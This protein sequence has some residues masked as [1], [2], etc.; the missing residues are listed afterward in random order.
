[1]AIVFLAFAVADA[2]GDAQSVQ[3]PSVSRVGGALILCLVMLVCSAAA[4]DLVMRGRGS[5]AGMLR[6][7]VGGQLAKYVPG[8]IAQVVGQAGL[9]V[10][11]G[12]TKSQAVAGVAVHSLVGVVAPSLL[13][14]SLWSLVA[15]PFPTWLRVTSALASTIASLALVAHPTLR[16]LARVAQVRLRRAPDWQVPCW[17]AL[18]QVYALGL[19]ALA[20]L[21]VAFATLAG[22]TSD[23]SDVIAA[24]GGYGVAFFVGFLAVPIP[25]GIGVREGALLAVAAPNDDILTALAAAACLR[26]LQLICEVLVA[27][28]VFGTALWHRQRHASGSHNGPAALGA[29]GDSSKE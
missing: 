16:T 26:I 3:W 13:F 9:A 4:W 18:L 14:V 12:A 5:R 7:F 2:R 19:A 25:A 29:E 6:S 21:S 15:S 10:A 17:R 27:L 22:A 1:M 20:A 8:G 11:A 23:T 28:P 24:A